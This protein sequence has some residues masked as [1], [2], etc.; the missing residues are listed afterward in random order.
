MTLAPLPPLFLASI[1]NV[2]IKIEGCSRF[3][4]DVN[5]ISKWFFV[6]QDLQLHGDDVYFSLEDMAPSD[7]ATA[8]H[9]QSK[10]FFFKKTDFFLV[11][12][13]IA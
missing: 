11:N 7:A 6:L 10:V 1:P 2:R 9:Y 5:L 8:N 3:F 13:H 4:L 12:G